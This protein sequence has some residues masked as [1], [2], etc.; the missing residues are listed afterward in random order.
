[1]PAFRLIALTFLAM[2]AFAANSLLCRAALKLSQMDAASFTSLRLLSGALILCLLVSLRS[3]AL[4]GS[5]SW[6]SACAL[7]AYAAG[8]SFAYQHLSA[9][10]GALLLF[11]AVQVSMIAYGISQGERLQKLQVAGLLLAMGG[12]LGLLLPGLSAPPLGS[13][14]LMMGA[15]LA[16]GIY[17]IRGKGAGDPSAATAMNFVY[18]TPIALAL[19]WLLRD[20]IN[21]DSAGVVYAILSG[22]LASGLGYALWYR[23]VPM[24][25][26][27]QAASVQLSVPV[28]TALGG[29]A[30]LGEPI[31]LRLLLASMAILGGIALMLRTKFR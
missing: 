30:L 11:G 20:T 26:S 27:T 9:A 31:T 1:M 14:L 12:L 13:A 15:G 8:F 5:G 16:W 29:V 10:S 17:S 4:R 2:L 7:F 18:A 28:F 24:L 23:V 25:Q 6:R 3:G 21:V 22:A 19:S